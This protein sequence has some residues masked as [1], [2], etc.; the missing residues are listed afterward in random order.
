MGPSAVVAL[1]PEVKD[2]RGGVA[3]L[4][5]DGALR[6]ALVESPALPGGIASRAPAVVSSSA[7]V[8]VGSRHI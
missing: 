5:V 6:G 3:S 1:N 4:V 2:E 8:R 7:P